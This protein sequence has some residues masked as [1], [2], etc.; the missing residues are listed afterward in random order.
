MGSFPGNPLFAQ[1]KPL[2][3]NAGKVL[4][5]VSDDAYTLWNINNISGW[6]RNDGESA[7][8]PASGVPGVKYPRLTAGVV[9]Q[10]GLVWGGR[11]TQSHFGG[12]PGSFRVGGQTYRI[13]TVPGH[14][15]IAGTPATPPVAADPNQASIY[16]IRA[17]W[18]SLTITDPQVIQDAAELNLIDPTMV[19]PAM[20]QA[21]LNDYQDDWNNW[22][23]HLGAP[24][25][26][27]NNNG[28]WDPG[29]DEPGLQDA[30][31]V[32]WF[33]INDLDADVT[34]D[35]YGSQPIGLEVQVTIWGYKS[36]GP[37]GQAVYQRYRIINKS[38][39]TVDSMF[40]AAKWMDPDIGT[41]H[42]D[43]AGCDTLLQAG[44]GYNSSAL[45]ADYQ[46][47]GLPPAAI[48]YTLLQG[49]RVPAPGDSAWFDFRRIAGYR[50]LPMTSF[51]YY[52][53]ASSISDPSFGD[54]YDTMRWNNLLNG[55]IY[56]PDTLNPEPFITGSGPN[57]GLP[58]RFP[59]SGDPATRNGDIDG[60]GNNRPPGDRQISINT[61]PFT[62]LNG[63]TQE[64]VLAVVGG[65]D[66]AGDHISAV[67]KM[68]EHIQLIRAQ[69]PGTARIPRGIY[70]VSH[71]GGTISELRVRVDLKEFSGITAAEARF[72]PEAGAE[73]G[74]N[75]AL[76]DD[77]AHRDSLAADGIWGNSLIVGNRKYSFKGDLA[78]QHASGV[79]QFEN[80]FTRMR[81]RPLPEF[82][83][84]RVD[85]ENGRQ[86]AGINYREKVRL[87]F[88]IENRD[89]ARDIS[90]ITVFNYAP[91]AKNQEI[92]FAQTIAPGETASN[93]QLNFFLRGPEQGDTL[94]FYY[95][96]RFDAHV[97]AFS[98]R[99]PLI[100]W[101]LPVVWGD[102]LAVSSLRGVTEHLFPIVA[103]PTLLDS[104]YYQISYFMPPDSSELRWRLRDLTNGMLRLDDQPVVNDPFY[105]HPVVDGIMFKVTNAEPGFR[106]FQVV[107]NAAGPLDPP[108]QGCYVFNRNGFP[109]LNGSDRPN[110]E[111]QQ[112]NGSTWA[113]H[114]AMTEG[115][116]GRYAY[117]ISRVSRQGVNWPRMIPNDFEIRF[118]AAGGKAWMKYTGNAIVDVPFELWHMGEHIDDRS[119]DYRLIP[120]VYD[121]DENGFF[122][123]TA[124]DH[125]VSGSDND[126]Y[127]D[128][129]DF[130][131][132]AD[133][134][135]G[136]AG[137]DAW[138]NSGFDEALVA[139]EIMARI[140]L[141]NRN[142]GSV[143][144]S[145]FP[146]NVNALLPEQGTIFRIVTNKPNFPGDTLLVL[147]YV[148][149][150]EVPL[151]ETFALYQNYPNPFNP[152]TQIRFDLAHQ[153]RVKLEI[154][155]LLGQRIKT[156]A[157]ADMA[158]GQH[159]VR[160][161]GRN[162]AGLRVSS[163]VY[164]YRLK[165]GDYVKSRKMILIR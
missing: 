48:G 139:A 92:Q 142:G 77:G 36:E 70:R 73:P 30:D 150:R 119:D 138:V 165:A 34:T 6:I 146:A 27:R 29:T 111:R 151:P 74:F 114:T 51:G 106:S 133:T 39:F 18:Q 93:E 164:F 148:E 99:Q 71:P 1:M 58:T 23:G 84:W 141:V 38:G 9:Y 156:L 159:R 149:N 124:I 136:S 69:Y 25:Y 8:E 49:P 3:Q 129:I 68:K 56:A 161:N 143:S 85:W 163:G 91:E 123:L 60:L 109:L 17:D 105:P 122:N 26:D 2:P 50:N 55:F 154:F 24:Y 4:G 57:A 66:P 32:I 10:D 40:L 101:T 72:A 33:V 76:F 83:H 94:R 62:F 47:F 44:F 131:N 20:T 147:G 126:P 13:G 67:Q 35:L 37:L 127:T 5:A 54:Y 158:P 128:G 95:R 78:L 42:D 86:D 118:T 19:T 88:D 157:D 107:A 125:V 120:L 16:R 7:H 87:R 100:P 15:A 79:Q 132:P 104:H 12:N 61:G 21:V 98:F 65:I 152:E 103:D 41:Y 162:A 75:L 112:S 14:I 82:T 43:F 113:I 153:V 155:N 102:T 80:L 53:L 116:N 137:Y 45:D 59:F 22:P 97:Q 130:Y 115:N 135:P 28:Q 90:E 81:L 63:D 121:E 160:W 140:V 52:P 64:V 96:L 110:P 11:V 108:E 144:D 31:Q 89:F 145:T 117:F 134:A 46:R